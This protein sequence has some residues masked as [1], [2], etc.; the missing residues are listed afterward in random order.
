MALTQTVFYIESPGVIGRVENPILS[1]MKLRI[2][3][4]TDYRLPLKALV[5]GFVNRPT[6][7]L[8]VVLCN[9]TFFN[10]ANQPVREDACGELI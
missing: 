6:A 8:K 10:T 7:K 1:R 4:K 2:R 5:S 3:T 9:H